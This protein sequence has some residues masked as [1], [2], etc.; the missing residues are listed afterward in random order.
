MKGSGTSIRRYI[1][2]V[3]IVGAP[4]T[5]PRRELDTCTRE[6]SRT[7]VMEISKITICSLEMRHS[8]IRTQHMKRTRLQCRRTRATAATCAGTDDGHSWRDRKRRSSS[9]SPA[10]RR[11]P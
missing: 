4:T 5:D 6:K 1:P 11:K 9:A 7:V 8:P 10:V 3:P 2:R